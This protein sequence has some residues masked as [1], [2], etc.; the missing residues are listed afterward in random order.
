MIRGSSP[1]E[2]EPEAGTCLGRGA[3]NDRD[4]DRVVLAMA[5]G[6]GSNNNL[7]G[8]SGGGRDKIS[9][10]HERQYNT[11]TPRSREIPLV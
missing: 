2:P 10:P 11:H 4:R 5:V 8:T 1:V 6:T 3:L 7:V 9:S